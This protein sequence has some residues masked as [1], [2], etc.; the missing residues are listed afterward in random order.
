LCFP[1]RPFR[2]ATVQTAR[3][4]SQQGAEPRVKRLRV[5]SAPKKNVP[6]ADVIAAVSAM[7]V[8]A[9]LVAKSP[10]ASAPLRLLIPPRLCCQR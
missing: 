1:E 9:E 5:S 10:R 8:V 2:A 3:L 7:P 6:S 4:G